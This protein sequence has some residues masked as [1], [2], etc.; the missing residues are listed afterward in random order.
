M[1]RDANDIAREEGMDALRQR[2][3][4]PKQPEAPPPAYS[5]EDLAL[6]FAKRHA[7]DLRYVAAWTQWLVWDGARWAKDDTRLAFSMGRA[8]CREAAAEFAAIR[9]NSGG[10]AIALAS[11][12][13]RAAVITLAND[14]RR[15]AATA[16]QWDA[17]PNLFNTPKGG[18]R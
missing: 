12:K 13:T 18:T 16:N 14:D 1:T 7:A 17:E 11:A 9:N 3:D 6:R 8:I 15:L 10:K 5:D 2:W 4:Q